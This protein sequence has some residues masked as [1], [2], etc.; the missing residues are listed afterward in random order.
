ML[1]FM[2]PRRPE[3]VVVDNDH[4]NSALTLKCEKTPIKSLKNEEAAAEEVCFT[5]LRPHTT[6]ALKLLH[7]N[8]CPKLSPQGITALVNHCRCLR[9]LSLSYSLLSDELLKALRDKNVQLETL[10]IEAHPESKSLPSVSDEA[11]S[12]L[13]NHSPNINLVLLSYMSDE[14]DCKT[15][16]KSCI[17]VTHLYL[18]ESTPASIVD[19]IDSCCGLTE[20]VI[21]AYGPHTIDEPLIR[22]A[23]SCPRLC[24]V[25]LGDCE[26]TSSGFLEFVSICCIRL[27][28]LRVWETSILEDSKLD[29]LTVSAKVSA[30]LGHT[31][32]PESVPFY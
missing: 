2:S 21:A 15:I 20:L 18:G 6:A 13:S 25:G 27:R 16:L 10:R 14:E 17:P 24:A 19:G 29:V 1:A 31:W 23:K 7:I 22:A 4:F 5:T 26:I 28:V 3:I 8:D 11:W 9:E 32:Y 30:L 12:I